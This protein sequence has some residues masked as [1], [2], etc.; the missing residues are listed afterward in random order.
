MYNVTLYCEWPKKKTPTD[1]EA[2]L[3]KVSRWEKPGE[4][5]QERD[6]RVEWREKKTLFAG[7]KQN[8]RFYRKQRD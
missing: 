1:A 4:A 2:G 8:D 6:E 5:G 3:E 7:G